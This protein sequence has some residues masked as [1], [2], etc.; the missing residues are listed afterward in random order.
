MGV[1][2]SVGQGGEQPCSLPVT[3]RGGSQLIREAAAIDV[4]EGNKRLAVLLADLVNLDDVG[5]LQPGHRFRFGGKTGASGRAGEGAGQDHFQSD[6]SFES[7]MSR[8]V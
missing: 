2:N 7:K 3:K 4:F 1:V 5:M 8:Q 6:E